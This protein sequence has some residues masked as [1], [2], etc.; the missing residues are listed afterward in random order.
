MPSSASSLFKSLIRAC[1]SCGGQKFD[2]NVP[3]FQLNSWLKKSCWD[4]RNLAVTCTDLRMQ[5]WSAPY[6]LI[7][8][9]SGIFL[10]TS[11]KIIPLITYWFIRPVKWQFHLDTGLS[12]ADFMWWL[13]WIQF[14][15]H[16]PRLELEMY[17]A[18]SMF[19]FYFRFC[20]VWSMMWVV[21]TS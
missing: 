14:I 3:I 11:S 5:L 10:S 6:P 19:E 18:T 1:W 12:P 2:A 4:Q 21:C 16:F 15:N 9:I 8:T 13:L 7:C 20:I 17:S